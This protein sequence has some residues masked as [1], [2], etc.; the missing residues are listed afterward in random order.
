[1][2]DLAARLAGGRTGRGLRDD[3]ELA[4]L[5]EASTP[6]EQPGHRRIGPGRQAL[7]RPLGDAPPDQSQIT[8]GTLTVAAQLAAEPGGRIGAPGIA[9][10]QARR[11]ALKTLDLSL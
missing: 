6:R 11:I 5:R 8:I 4:R 10:G 9:G 1:R 3:G 2:H 7:I